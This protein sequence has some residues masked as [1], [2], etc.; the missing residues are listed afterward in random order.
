MIKSDVMIS[1]TLKS[2]VFLLCL[3][4]NKTEGLPGDLPIIPNMPVLITH[5]I[6]TKL[7]ISNGSIGRLVK[8]VYE[9]EEQS[10]DA[11]AIGDSTF[12]SNTVYI[13]KPLYALVQLPQCKIAF[14]LPDL[15][16]T[17]VPIV[18]EQ[19]TIKV[20]LKSILS[21]AQKRL[22]QNKTTITITRCQLPL[23]PA[24]TM[25]THKCQGKTLQSGVID[26]VPPPYP[27]PNL[28]QT[29]VPISRFTS[30]EAMAILRPF[31]RSILNQKP[32]LDMLVEF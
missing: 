5:N 4:D 24:Y 6:A 31:P 23:I 22:L 20:D 29:Y 1:T 3:P 28:A 12:S 25:T 2:D 14:A 30:L 26:I 19:K 16:P 32:H 21:S 13:R 11:T 27:K 9:D 18:P 15:Q 8:V 10:Y 17:L 7:H